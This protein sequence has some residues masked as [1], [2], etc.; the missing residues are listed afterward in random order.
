MVDDSLGHITKKEVIIFVIDMQN[1]PAPIVVVNSNE[2]LE[3]DNKTRY[4]ITTWKTDINDTLHPNMINIPTVGDGYYYSVDWGDGTSSK[5]VR[6]DI[7]HTY[8]RAGVYQVKILGDF[9]RIYFGGGV[10]WDEN[11]TRIVSP[12]NKKILSVDQWGD[13]NWSSM[14]G[15]FEGCEN[16]EILA[17][18]RPN[19]YNVKDMRWMFAY[20]ESFNQDIGDW[21]VSNVQTIMSDMF[22]NAKK[23]IK[24]IGKWDV[25]H[26]SEY[27]VGMVGLFRVL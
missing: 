2:P 12:N 10:S 21:D 23:F 9:P 24:D 3:T 7:N 16:L 25:S 8:S 18:D 17:S 1:E 15:A 11:Y 14:R 26:G 13:I 19:L 5:N 4:F 22:N 27:A 6:E 20:T